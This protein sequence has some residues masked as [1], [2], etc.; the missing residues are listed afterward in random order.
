MHKVYKI[1]TVTVSNI[2]VK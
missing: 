2:K 1:S